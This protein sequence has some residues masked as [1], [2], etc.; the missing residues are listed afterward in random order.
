LVSSAKRGE[1]FGFDEG[2]NQ[3]LRGV[4]GRMT[5]STKPLDVVVVLKDT[6]VVQ[7]LLP[8]KEM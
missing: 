5:A 4:G 3:D 2:D 8:G 7:D 1:E 6:I